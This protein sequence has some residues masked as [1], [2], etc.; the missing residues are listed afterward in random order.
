MTPNINPHPYPIATA[1]HPNPSSSNVESLMV[2]MVVR[3]HC[4]ILLALE[5]HTN[6]S[7]LRMS[8]DQT[9][10]TAFLWVWVLQAGYVK[11]LGLEEMLDLPTV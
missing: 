6:Q 11:G 7:F 3:R 1:F 8:D 4:Y 2:V 5:I 10:W 9:Y